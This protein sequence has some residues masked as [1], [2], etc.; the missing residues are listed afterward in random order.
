M[1]DGHDND[2]GCRHP[3]KDAK[4]EPPHQGAPHTPMEYR[5]RAGVLG[6]RLKCRQEFIERFLPEPNPL[7]FVPRSRECYVL[8]RLVPEPDRVTHS[9]RRMRA[10]ASAAGCPGAAL[11]S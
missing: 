7:L 2:V 11:V 6:D 10:I 1:E 9:R 5:V 3:E 8:R 4:W